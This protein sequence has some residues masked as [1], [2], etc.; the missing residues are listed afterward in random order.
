MDCTAF[1]N[2]L[3]EGAPPGREIPVQE[4]LRRCGACAREFEAARSLDWAL[5]QRIATVPTGFTDRVMSSLPRRTAEEAPLSLPPAQPSLLQLLKAGVLNLN[6]ISATALLLIP[7]I[8]GIENWRR[9]MESLPLLGEKIVA[10]GMSGPA[11]SLP[12]LSF[13]PATLPLIAFPAVAVSIYLLYRIGETAGGF[14]SSLA[15]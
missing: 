15:D 1:R 10:F 7:W 4:H 8:S 14:F 11:V 5:G 2:W 13:L 6:V 9:G 12:P 3:D